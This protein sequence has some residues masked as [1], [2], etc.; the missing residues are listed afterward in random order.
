MRCLFSSPKNLLQ[1]LWVI[2]LVPLNL[3]ERTRA[4]KL[5]LINRSADIFKWIAQKQNIWLDVFLR[6]I[7]VLTWQNWRGKKRREIQ[8]SS[9]TSEC[10][11]NLKKKNN[12][13]RSSCYF[14]YVLLCFNDS[15]W[16]L[17]FWLLSLVLGTL[18]T[19]AGDFQ[20]DI[21]NQEVEW[22]PLLGG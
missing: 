14:T 1:P 6:S 19:M 18:I 22:T 12:K 17:V 5:S 15:G 21:T 9:L 20:R 7:F 3:D 10:P 13:I 2:F 16:L 8:S 11:L 4:C